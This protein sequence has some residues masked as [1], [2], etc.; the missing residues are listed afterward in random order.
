MSLTLDNRPER[1]TFPCYGLSGVFFRYFSALNQ[2]AIGYQQ[3][4]EPV[5]E[6]ILNTQEQLR[7]A[8]LST[9]KKVQDERQIDCFALVIIS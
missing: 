7:R 4:H 1:G 2:A 6:L 5:P 9:S 8:I 3:K